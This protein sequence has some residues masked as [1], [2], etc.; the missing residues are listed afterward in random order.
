MPGERILILAGT[1]E[2]LS[3]TN[4]LVALG[5]DVISSFA[6]VTQ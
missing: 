1:A 2:A 6:G 3:L 5:V 4:A